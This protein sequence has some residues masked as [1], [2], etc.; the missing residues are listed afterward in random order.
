MTQYTMRP[1]LWPRFVLSFLTVVCVSSAARGQTTPTKLMCV[2]SSITDSRKIITGFPAFADLATYRYF[3]WHQLKK[4]GYVM[5]FVGSRTTI[6]AA[7]RIHYDF[8]ETKHE[9]KWDDTAADIAA[10]I[11]SAVISKLPDAVLLHTGTVDLATKTVATTIADIQLVIS[12]IQAGKPSGVKIYLAQIIPIATS[13]SFYQDVAPLNTAIAGLAS[14]DPTNPVIIVDHF[15]GWDP[16]AH[17]LNGVFPYETGEVRMANTWYQALTTGP[18]ALTAVNPIGVTA[19]FSATTP[20][21]GHSPSQCDVLQRFVAGSVW[22]T[23][24]AR[25]LGIR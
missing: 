22:W 17:T 6:P 18:H 8:F 10:R 13:S 2:G 12:E 20:T 21:T 4:H 14:A 7:T 23:V 1:A 3:L 5:D 11:K 24:H 25:V 9:G 19:L 15:T 16:A